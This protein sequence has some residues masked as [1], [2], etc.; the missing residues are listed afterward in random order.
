MNNGNWPSRRGLGVE[1]QKK[2]KPGWQGPKLGPDQ[3]YVV[4]VGPS[5]AT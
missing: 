5:P 2:E 4:I 3:T 1:E